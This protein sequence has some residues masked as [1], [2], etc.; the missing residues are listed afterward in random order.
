MV[1]AAVRSLC[2]VAAQVGAV[3]SLGWM[4]EELLSSAVPHVGPGVEMGICGDPDEYSDLVSKW[5]IDCRNLNLGVVSS[6]PWEG[7]GGWQVLLGPTTW[8]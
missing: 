8:Q 4:V 7:G 2:S 6:G 1:G 5:P 3:V